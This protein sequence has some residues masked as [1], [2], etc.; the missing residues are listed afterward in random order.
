MKQ[1]YVV[2]AFVADNRLEVTFP[3]HQGVRWVFAK[4]LA[5]KIE[6]VSRTHGFVSDDAVKAA[7]GTARVEFLSQEIVSY[8]VLS[9]RDTEL[10]DAVVFVAGREEYREQVLDS[11][12]L[13]VLANATIMQYHK[14]PKTPFPLITSNIVRGVIL[15]RTKE[16]ERKVEMFKSAI[17]KIGN[18]RALWKRRRGKKGIADKS[19]STEKFPVEN[20][21]YVMFSR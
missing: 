4:N 7:W 12:L 11:D 19:P 6:I 1:T 10:D 13:R 8:P 20:N 5:G 15:S 14:T 16:E 21:Q 18:A 3:D 2:S 17:C 9:L